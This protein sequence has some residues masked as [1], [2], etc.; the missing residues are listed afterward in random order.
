ML[1]ISKQDYE[2]V[3]GLDTDFPVAYN[4]IDLCLKIRQK[5]KLVV[6]NPFV[7]AYHFESRT[8]GYET[9]KEKENRLEEDTKKLKNKWSSILKSDIYA[10]V[11]DYIKDYLAY[12]YCC[13]LII[14]TG[15]NKYDKRK[16]KTL[17]KENKSILKSGIS[18]KVKIASFIC[19]ASGI[20]IGSR[21]L[22]IY[23][24]K[25]HK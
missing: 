13:A 4:D 12:Q 2:E 17:L 9:T 22:K 8:R 14:Y 7:Q 18:K 19:S 16:T 6:L 15:L 10:D 5:N 25:R 23:H 3:G 11:R 21:L 1:M 24:I 20:T